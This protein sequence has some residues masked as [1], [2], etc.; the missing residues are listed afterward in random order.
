MLSLLLLSL[1]GLSSADITATPHTV[2][3]VSLEF[4]IFSQPVQNDFSY[5]GNIDAEKYLNYLPHTLH[6]DY[7]YN[8]PSIDSLADNFDLDGRHS[9]MEQ[10]KKVL[11][12]R[13]YPFIYK[14][15]AVLLDADGRNSWPIDSL[16]PQGQSE[17]SDTS[18]FYHLRGHVDLQFK[19]YYDLTTSL[20][21]EP[22]HQKP[23]LS[24]IDYQKEYRRLKPKQLHYFDHERIGIL[25]K[26]TP[27]PDTRA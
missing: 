20:T 9:S 16:L 13:G 25:A 18:N 26:I 24:F 10:I 4:I 8:A 6:D 1:C 17:D 22:R 14:R 7:G 11:S 12:K 2:V 27:L 15:W 5:H 3:P 23:G 19:H 21:I